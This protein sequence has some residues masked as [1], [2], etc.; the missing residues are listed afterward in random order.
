VDT[1]H[2]DV[3]RSKYTTVRWMDSCHWLGRNSRVELSHL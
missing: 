1:V 3:G 2:S